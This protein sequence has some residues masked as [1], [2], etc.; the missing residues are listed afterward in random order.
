MI[1][2]IKQ[3]EKKLIVLDI[4]GTL[5]KDNE[6]LSL[7]AKEVLSK[8]VKEGHE[9]VFASG[10]PIRAILPYYESIGCHSPIIAYNGLWSHRPLTLGKKPGYCFK[11]E[12]VQK[13]YDEVKDK[14]ASFMA[15]SETAIYSLIHDDYLDMFFPYKGMEEIAGPSLTFKEDLL[16]VL[17]ESSKENEKYIEEAIS[18]YPE[19]GFRRWTNSP[20]S[21][22]YRIGIDKGFGVK[23]IQNALGIS[24]ENTIAIGDSDNDFTML[25]TAKT[26]Y[27]IK[28]SKSKKLLSSFKATDKSLAEDGAVLILEELLLKK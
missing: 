19:Y 3:M 11:K 15:E 20:Y 5:I 23:L 18:A 7:K 13:I 17:F 6:P 9:V 1:S 21:E 25:E 26:A 22:L 24:K 27:A 10:R 8:L 28:G 12:D 4:D 16:T 2:I 14:V